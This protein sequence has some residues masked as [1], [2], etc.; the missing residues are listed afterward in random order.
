MSSSVD[1]FF[2]SALSVDEF[3]AWA[4]ED[5]GLTFIKI[6]GQ[7]FPYYQCNYLGCCL[8]LERTTSKEL[9][10]YD[11][12]RMNLRLCLDPAGEASKVLALTVLSCALMSSMEGGGNGLLIYDCQAP[13]ARA[14]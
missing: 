2:E 4:L 9:E 3:P 12:S 11:L 10:G 8:F 6:E 14:F 5:L 13:L 7:R 1:F